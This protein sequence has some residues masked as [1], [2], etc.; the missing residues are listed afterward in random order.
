MGDLDRVYANRFEDP[1]AA[2]KHRLWAEIGPFLE[3][4]IDAGAP[5]LDIACDRGYFIAHVRAS[6]KWASDMRDVAS[7]LPAD[8]K[9]VQSSGL[10]LAGVVPRGHFGTV[11]MSNY[12]EHLPSSD[13]VLR[14]LAVAAELLRP[15]GRV[16]VLQPNIRFVG[17]AYWDFID[18]KTAL[19]ERSLTE[20]AEVAGFV[21]ERV[22]RRFLPYTTKSRLPQSP[23]LVR[24]YLRVPLAWRFLGGQTLYVGRRP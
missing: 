13:H 22:I 15:G 4:F 19:T 5:V 10:D 23:A 24:L 21:T 14:Q 8:V 20:A 3:R 16:V 7:S 17:A 1:D 11:F 6:E 9:F 12:L 18:H 2:A